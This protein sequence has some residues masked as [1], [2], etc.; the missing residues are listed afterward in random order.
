MRTIIIDAPRINLLGYTTINNGF[1][2]NLD[3]TF[4]ANGATI[5]GKVVSDGIYDDVI[6]D[7]GLITFKDA[8]DTTIAYVGDNGL[9]YAE[10]SFIQPNARSYVWASGFEINDANDNRKVDI[11]DVSAEFN[12]PV[13]AAGLTIN[14]NAIKAITTGKQTITASTVTAGSQGSCN[15]PIGI[16]GYTPLG[17]I[18]VE[19]E[20]NSNLCLV[21]FSL[22]DSSTARLVYV[23]TGTVS[24][25]PSWTVTILY[26]IN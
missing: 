7:D 1:K 8:N 11:T 24:R 9:G 22:L 26:V 4:E 16:S 18:A 5:N 23:N 25:T 19:G 10:I 6:V 12:V 3:G 20:E 13:S 14:G 17:I 21:Q 15:I 2:V